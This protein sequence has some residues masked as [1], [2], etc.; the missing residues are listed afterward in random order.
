MEL[1]PNGD[2]LYGERG[3]QFFTFK[4]LHMGAHPTTLLQPP[5]F[6]LAIQKLL[7]IYSTVEQVNE[8]QRIGASFLSVREKKLE[9]S[10]KARMSPVVLAQSWRQQ[11]ELSVYISCYTYIC[12]LALSLERAQKRSYLVSQLSVPRWWFLNTILQ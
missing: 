10:T 11:C 1:A 3:R 4:S 9:I 2:A 8:V 6:M 7:Y 5:W 12:F